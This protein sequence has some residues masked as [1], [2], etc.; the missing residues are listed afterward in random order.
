MASSARA[1][2]RRSEVSKRAP[3]WFLP[4]AGGLLFAV[5]IAAV[6]TSAGWY[7]DQNGWPSGSGY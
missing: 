7:L 1:Q 6:L 3:G 5:L 2:P 4:V